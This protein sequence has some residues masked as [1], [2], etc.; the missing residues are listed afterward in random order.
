MS[1]VDVQ[2]LFDALRAEGHLEIIGTEA[3]II[4][5]K[6][7]RCAQELTLVVPP[8]LHSMTARCSG[9]SQPCV[10]RSHRRHP[11]HGP[12]SPTGNMSPQ[13]LLSDPTAEVH[14]QV[15]QTAAV[16]SHC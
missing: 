15:W 10:L 3:S 5:S 2:Q 11:T 16:D 8:A 1:K 7:R 9:L 6:W 12:T 4:E 13:Q 14:L